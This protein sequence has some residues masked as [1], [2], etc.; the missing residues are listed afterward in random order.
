MVWT[1]TEGSER[2]EYVYFRRDVTL[3]ERPSEASINLYADSR[4]A[5]YVNEIYIGFGPARTFHKNPT[6]DTY[7]IAPY[8]NKGKNTIAVKALSNGMVTFQL[9]DYNGGFTAWGDI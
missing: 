8:L 4:Y 2:N 7:D 3:N 9:F 5:L 6:Y 1:N